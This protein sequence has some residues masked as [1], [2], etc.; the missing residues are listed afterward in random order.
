MGKTSEALG[1]VIMLVVDTNIIL[2]DHNNLF[3]L[4]KNYP[5]YEICI[6]ETVVE[7]LDSKKTVMGEIGYQAR[8]LGRLISRAERPK[9]KMIID[10]EGFIYSHYIVDGTNLTIITAPSYPEIN[11]TSTSLTNDDRIVYVAQQLNAKLVTNDVMCRIRAEIMGVDSTDFKHVED[12]KLEFTKHLTVS[13]SD[14]INLHNS[15]VDTIDPDYKQENFSYMFT[16]EDSKVTKLSTIVNGSIKVIGKESERELR[17]QSVNPSNKEQ[18]ILASLI[19]DST[20]DL[21]ICEA[22]A[23]S[24]KTLTALS[25]AIKLMDT[26]NRYESITYIRNTVDDVANSDE[27]IGFLGGNDEKM[28]VYLEPFYDTLSTIVRMNNKFTSKGSLLEEAVTSKVDNLVNSY[29]MSA[30]VALGLRGRTLDNSIII[31]DEAQ[32]ISKATM[33]K[34]LSRVGKNSKVIVIGS[35]RQI[36]SKYLTKY[37]SG[38]SVLL[39]ASKRTDLP[40]NMN[41]VSLHKV[42][43][44]PV[45]EFAEQ[46]FSNK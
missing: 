21:T 18:L 13:N 14:F 12:T 24:G 10:N 23:G 20:V 15:V 4:A 2:L 11:R 44:G 40:I 6:P 34:I 3:T 16:C 1:E 42:V 43:R 25:N 33:Q 7:E 46:I 8:A 17:S 28:A 36:D 26:S 45:T 35:L 32:N 37:T 5:G 30:I 9:N 27:E 19:Q 41:A 29:N 31:V 39:D 22:L 38:L